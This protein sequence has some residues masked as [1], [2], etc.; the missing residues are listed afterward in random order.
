[1]I[2]LE[3]SERLVEMVILKPG[4]PE[5]KDQQGDKTLTS[6]ITIKQ[7]CFYLFKKSFKKKENGFIALK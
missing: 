6:I 7:L 3:A 5:L 1:M 2:V 4:F